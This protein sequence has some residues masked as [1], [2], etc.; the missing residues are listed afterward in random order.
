MLLA[1]PSPRISSSTFSAPSERNIGPPPRRV[2]AAGNDHGRAA[3]ELPFAR[4]GSVVNAGT[5]EVLAPLGLQTTV[6][7]A[8]RD[9]DA[10]R[11]QSGVA[12]LDL[13]DRAVLAVGK[14]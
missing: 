12:A 3:A 14:C 4:R 8:R 6:I 10:L 2:A 11:Q 5:F 7:R 13:Q 9:D 1:R